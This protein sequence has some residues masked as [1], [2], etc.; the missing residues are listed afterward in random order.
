MLNVDNDGVEIAYEILNGESSKTPICFIA[1]LGGVRQSVMS[2]ASVFAKDRPVVLHDHRGT[3]QSAKPLGV[4]SIETMASDMIAVLDDAGIEKAH[5]AGFSTG[6]AICQVLTLNYPDRVQSVALC[7]TWPKS[8]HF[9]RRQFECR[10]Q[11]L[12]EQ[13]TDAVMRLAS[14]SLHDPKY[15]TDHY[16]EVVQWEDRAIAGAGP[17]EVDAERMD[18]I[19]AHDQLDRLGQITRPTIIMCAR[20]DAVCPDYN[21]KLMAEVIPQA[22]L[23]LYEDGGHFFYVAR[24]DEFNADLAGFVARHE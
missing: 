21:S 23:K 5:F 14:V 1:G 16:E 3:G 8:D 15:F 17:R 13:G 19:I 2:P 18:A 11:M 24:A 7:C 12:L 10:K 9:F 22:E 4:Y 6:G 20:N